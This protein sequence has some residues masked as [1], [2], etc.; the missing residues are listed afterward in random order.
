MFAWEEYKIHHSKGNSEIVREAL[1]YGSLECIEKIVSS[2]LFQQ[3]QMNVEL[4]CEILDDLLCEFIIHSLSN[5]LTDSVV[6]LDE[7]NRIKAQLL[8]VLTKIYEIIPEKALKFWEDFGDWNQYQRLYS[9]MRQPYGTSFPSKTIYYTTYMDTLSAVAK[10]ERGA[11][12]IYEHLQG[13]QFIGWDNFFEMINHLLTAYRQYQQESRIGH[14][15]HPTNSRQQSSFGIADDDIIILK[16]IL[17]LIFQ[18][19]ENSEQVRIQITN[20]PKWEAIPIFFEF[21]SCAL[22]IPLRALI[23][24]VISSF[25]I[26]PSIAQRIWP[27]LEVQRTYSRSRINSGE[28]FVHMVERDLQNV[29][30]KQQDYSYTISFLSLLKRLL[31]QDAFSTFDVSI[32]L[33]YT[34]NIFLTFQGRKYENITQLWKISTLCLEIYYNILKESPLIPLISLTNSNS[35]LHEKNILENQNNQQQ[36]QRGKQNIEKKINQSIYIPAL[37]LLSDFTHSKTDSIFNTILHILNTSK[38]KLFSLRMSDSCGFYFEKST[39]LCISIL[40]NV[41]GQEE[42]FSIYFPDKMLTSPSCYLLYEKGSIFVKK[43]LYLLSYPYNLKIPL[44]IIKIL[45]LLSQSK[46]NRSSSHLDR[47]TRIINETKISS[48]SSSFDIEYFFYMLLQQSNSNDDKIIREI[49]ESILVLFLK[50]IKLRAPNLSHLLLGFGTEIST[51]KRVD[52]NKQHYSCIHVIISSLYNSYTFPS[53]EPILCEQY[54][55][56]LYELCSNSNTCE[57]ILRYL[58]NFEDF[59]Q[60]QLQIPANFENTKKSS[61]SSSLSD[62]Y[63]DYSLH[64]SPSGVS[65]NLSDSTN[66]EDP[67]HGDHDFESNKDAYILLQRSWLLKMLALE[68]HC[69]A[70]ERRRPSHR[71]LGYLL[72][73][74]ENSQNIMQPENLTYQQ[75]QMMNNYSYQQQQ[76]QQNT[77]LS[78]QKPSRMKIIELLDEIMTPLPKI[79]IVPSIFDVNPN[80]YRITTSQGISYIDIKYLTIV[81]TERIKKLQQENLATQI[82]LESYRIQIKQIIK[83]AIEQNKFYE[84]LESKLQLFESWKQIIEIMLFEYFEHVRQQF[85][86]LYDFLEVLL[87]YF[88]NAGGIGGNSSAGGSNCF[89]PVDP[90]AECISGSVLTIMSKLHQLFYFSSTNSSSGYARDLPLTKLHGILNGF[91]KAIF[92]HGT[93]Q[94]MRGNLYISLLYFLRLTRYQLDQLP[95]ESKEQTSKMWW[96][97]GEIS[98]NQKLMRGNIEILE[99]HGDKLI[100]LICKDAASGSSEVWKCTAFALLDTLMS[101]DRKYFWLNLLEQRGFLRLFVNEIIQQDQFLQKSILSNDLLKLIFVYESRM[102]FFIHLSSN[103]P[104]AKKLVS[105]EII[106]CLTHCNFIDQRPEPNIIYQQQQQSPDQDE[107]SSYSYDQSSK[108]FNSISH[109][110]HQLLIPVLELISSLL[111]TLPDDL[112]L[113]DQVL[114]FIDSHSELFSILLRNRLPVI[115]LESLKELRLCTLIFYRISKFPDK[116]Q[117]KLHGQSLKFQRLLVHLLAKYFSVSFSN[118]SDYNYNSF[119]SSSSRKLFFDPPKESKRVKYEISSICQNLAAFC[120]SVSSGKIPSLVFTFSPHDNHID[121]DYTMINGN[122]PSIKILIDFLKDSHS[123]LI[124]AQ[125]LV[126][127]QQEKLKSSGDLS[128]EDI[129]HLDISDIPNVAYGEY[130]QA[131]HQRVVELHLQDMITDSY[132]RI[133]ILQCKFFCCFFF[134]RFFLTLFCFR[135]Y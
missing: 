84:I 135:Y 97:A 114:E 37:T 67:L 117:D 127:E 94:D 48:S 99:R 80:Q 125:K 9:F 61:S 73:S 64:N 49:K 42:N 6:D 86:P 23:M 134:K 26:T 59:Y 122:S 5:L 24:D 126:Q 60:T 34:R 33:N 124:S 11:I 92:Y 78:I 120:F 12:H 22:P 89:L 96:I 107:N 103:I 121:H 18:V 58:R 50:N 101:Y 83:K 43:I 36:Q 3:D 53:N 132:S 100:E 65:S 93:S 95:L 30:S 10:T 2:T 129:M 102:S 110:Y 87:H 116:C 68:L 85:G 1:S 19:C 74:S 45:I 81:L 16:S 4:F 57:S 115:H 109:R 133:S 7:L 54:Y 98:S 123:E 79:Q 41:I 77:P 13:N 39:L 105:S 8:C 108:S 29:E 28:K 72:Q 20:N 69:N 27:F 111:T 66:I 130:E 91:I 21:V 40:E 70:A 14:V 38:S 62:N 55:H 46:F 63:D 82:N 47:L 52:F 17:K 131:E 76:Q 113:I 15:H 44:G 56:L 25:A 112:T 51:M 35:N 31:N 106:Q 32:Y 75:Q 128:M 118:Y 88:F 104:G 71:L 90:L 119:N